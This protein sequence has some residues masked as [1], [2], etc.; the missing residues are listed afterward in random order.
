M[1]WER[2]VARGCDDER[3]WQK[4]DQ[5]W[6]AACAEWRIDESVRAA[7]REAMRGVQL[8]VDARKEKR[9]KLLE[10]EETRLV[11]ARSKVQEEL[12]RLR[13]ERSDLEAGTWFWRVFQPADP[14]ECA[15][16]PRERKQAH[17]ASGNG[18]CG[19]TQKWRA[20]LRARRRWAQVKQQTVAT[21]AGAS[22]EENRG[23]REAGAC[24][25]GSP[26][27]ARNV[28][29]CKAFAAIV[30]RSAVA[31]Q[32]VR[33]VKGRR[34]RVCRSSP[35]AGV[36]RRSAR[37]LPVHLPARSLAVEAE[38]QKAARD[39]G[40][41]VVDCGS[42]LGPW[43]GK[44][45]VN[46]V[47]ALCQGEMRERVRVRVL[48]ACANHAGAGFGGTPQE[49]NNMEAVLCV[50]H[51]ERFWVEVVLADS[52][53]SWERGECAGAWSLGATGAECAGTILWCSGHV[54]VVRGNAPTGGKLAL[55]AP[56]P[57]WMHDD[58]ARGKKGVRTEKRKASLAAANAARLAK[59][60]ESKGK[61]AAEGGC[62]EGVRAYRSAQR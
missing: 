53:S 36:S 45:L 6:A 35:G 32:S 47:L 23:K 52:V 51:S 59:Q 57:P 39:D 62:A 24:V 21:A 50:M 37:L 15:A 19:G 54:Y 60:A 34:Y 61:R 29:A 56:L 30:R 12:A 38:V 25:S 58:V 40:A 11:L 41:C 4:S 18:T 14:E 46:A 42:K 5:A 7:V 33:I 26:G 1:A 49:R 9:E 16:Q 44:C 48:L 28:W 55:R 2:R 3:W 13:R 17:S 31:T 8:R 43:R 22:Q 20:H 10:E 27:P